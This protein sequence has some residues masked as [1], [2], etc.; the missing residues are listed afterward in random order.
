MF[1]C[2]WTAGASARLLDEYSCTYLHDGRSPSSRNV[3]CSQSFQQIIH[4]LLILF[5]LYLFSSRYDVAEHDDMGRKRPI[6]IQ[7]QFLLYIPNYQGLLPV[8]FEQNDVWTKWIWIG[9]LLTWEL[10]KK[11][12]KLPNPEILIYWILQFYIRFFWILFYIIF[13]NFIID[14][15]LYIISYFI[16]YK[17]DE[18]SLNSFQKFEM[19]SYS[20]RHWRWGWKSFI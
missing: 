18:V 17:T 15:T 2:C 10:M 4:R 12:K 20:Y 11:E 3:V 5:F 19:I 7:F 1:S 9:T 14:Y 8:V 16:L 6:D 13:F